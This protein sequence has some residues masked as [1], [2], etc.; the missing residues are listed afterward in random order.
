MET[1]S[2][3]SDF[4]CEIEKLAKLGLCVD[5]I[6][7]LV[8]YAHMDFKE[9]FISKIK[10]KTNPIGRAY[11]KGKYTLK[12]EVLTSLKQLA[13]NGS[14]PAIERLIKQIDIQHNSE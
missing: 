4:L 7:V 12:V 10:D 9:T 5:E 3:I 6:E 8:D 13:L 2:N 1:N 14:T 11:L